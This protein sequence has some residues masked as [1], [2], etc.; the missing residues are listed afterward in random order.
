MP[1]GG[2]VMHREAQYVNQTQKPPL[3]HV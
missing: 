1:N 3:N 2:H